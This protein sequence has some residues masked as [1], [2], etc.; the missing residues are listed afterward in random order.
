MSLTLLG[1][2]LGMTR[3]F[4][5]NGASIPVT[6]IE[7]GPCV[8]TQLRTV[9][10]D[11]YAA[12]Q[13]GFGD[14]KARNSTFQVIA[15]DAKAGTGPKRMHKEFKVAADK[16]GEYSL[17]QTLTVEALGDQKYVDVT[18]ISKG[19]GFAGVM[20]RYRF[21]GMCASHGTERKHRSPGS[22]GAHASNRG[23]GGGLKKGKKM[24]GHMGDEQVTVR[25]LDV[26]K[27]DPA[28]N[29]IL[30][31][32]PIP[33]ANTGFVSIRACTRLNRSKQKKLADGASK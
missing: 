4:G 9:E 6:V 29:L 31:K 26:I 24:P 5:E 3:V 11:G 25:S 7:C 10:T 28:Q 1:K 19:K 13:V 20:K 33:G 18:G 32:G 22:I 21:K 16:I 2:K 14:Q 8:V 15:H 27:I 30:V 12:V 23:F 17:G